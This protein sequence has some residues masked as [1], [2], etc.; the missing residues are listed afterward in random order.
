MQLRLHGVL[1]G[2]NPALPLG[3]QDPTQYTD[4]YDTYT[5]LTN[6]IRFTSPTDQRFRWIVGA[7][8]QRQSDDIRVEFRIDGLPAF[9]QVTG[10]GDVF[11]LS[12]QDRIDRDHAVFGDATFDI[13]DKLKVSAGL[14]YFWVDNTLFGFFGFN[15]NGYSSN[16][17]ASCYVNGVFPLH[18]CDQPAL[19]QYR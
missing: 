4:N 6:E 13:T 8:Q 17:E 15:N 3:N 1:S 5:K 16:G 2:G 12:Q 9:Y 10:Q 7:F 11:Y 14:R 19:H 18:Q